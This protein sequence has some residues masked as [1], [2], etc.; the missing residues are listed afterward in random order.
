MN[1]AC[2]RPTRNDLEETVTSFDH[3]VSVQVEAAFLYSDSVILQGDF[4]AKLGFEVISHDMNPMPKNGEK[5][6][7]LF[8]K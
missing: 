5:L 7:N 6:L 8:C 4:N 1:H 2:I 3:D